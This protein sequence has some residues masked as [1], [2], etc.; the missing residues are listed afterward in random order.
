MKVK[1]LVIGTQ[2]QVKA[3]GHTGF[4]ISSAGKCGTIVDI[5][6]GSHLDVRVQYNDGAF[7]WGNHKGIKRVK[8]KVG[9]RVRLVEDAGLGFLAGD[10]GTVKHVDS[11]ITLLVHFDVPR[12]GFKSP[13]YAIPD[14]QGLYVN[15]AQLEV[16]TD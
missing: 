9:S 10:V 5:D 11:P 14:L 15:R 12:N 1:N 16:I 4:Y 2:V 13:E 6:D 7:E 3:K 8:L